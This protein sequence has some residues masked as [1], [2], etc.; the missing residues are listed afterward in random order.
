[1]PH[2][3]FEEKTYTPT[4]TK[5]SVLEVPTLQ[6]SNNPPRFLCGVHPFSVTHGH[7]GA[8]FTPTVI[9]DLHLTT[10]QYHGKWQ[11]SAF[12]SVPPLGL[13]AG[14]L[15]PTPLTVPTMEESCAPV[16]PDPSAAGRIWGWTRLS[17]KVLLGLGH[18]SLWGY[19]LK[20]AQ[21]DS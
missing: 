9:T 5:R 2:P 15:S 16:R 1:M 13:G 8:P 11:R 20:P 12:L 17:V 21:S 10:W 19:E 6:R 7:W 14:L 18:S 3:N 4:V